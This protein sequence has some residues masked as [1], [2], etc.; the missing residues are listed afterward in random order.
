MHPP[1]S[2]S[3]ALSGGCG[4]PETPQPHTPSWGCSGLQ[5]LFPALRSGGTNPEPPWAAG[6]TAWQ[7][8]PQTG[9]H[10]NP[11]TAPQAG[12]G[13]RCPTLGRRPLPTP[14][15]PDDASP[16]QELPEALGSHPAPPCS[17]MIWVGSRQ[18]SHQLRAVAGPPDPP[19]PSPACTPCIGRA[20]SSR[21]PRVKMLRG[22]SQAGP[23]R[24]ELPDRWPAAT[25][26]GEGVGVPAPSAR[27]HR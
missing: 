1:S 11:F 21:G 18:D 13:K 5:V 6:Q 3:C 9:P 14:S 19:P 4:S 24:F 15:L 25:V 20:G 27:G 22:S 2:P 7:Q 26:P 17:G 23:G 16:T 8:D 10:R 12:P